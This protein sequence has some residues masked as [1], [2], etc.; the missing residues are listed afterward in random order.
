MERQTEKNYTEITLQTAGGPAE[1]AE[2][3][4]LSAQQAGIHPHRH[5]HTHT[6]YSQRGC[7]QTHRR[8]VDHKVINIWWIKEIDYLNVKGKRSFYEYC[9]KISDGRSCPEWG[10]VTKNFGKG[11]GLQGWGARCLGQ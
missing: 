9:K 7:E 5:T 6:H 8:H 1:A 10:V 2:F 3:P 11:Q 4:G